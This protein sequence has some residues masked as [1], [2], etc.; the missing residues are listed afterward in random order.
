MIAATKSNKP[1]KLSRLIGL[2]RALLPHR[3]KKI[4]LPPHVHAFRV[5]GLYHILV[6]ERRK[7]NDCRLLIMCECGHRIA[8]QQDY[9]GGLIMCWERGLIETSNLEYLLREVQANL[10]RNGLYP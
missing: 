6:G 4:V 9:I 2:M 3:K 5:V 1:K 8:I 7:H 10:V